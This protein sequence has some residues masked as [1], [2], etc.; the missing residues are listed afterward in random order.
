M[1]VGNFISTNIEIQNYDC[2]LND[3]LTMI[4]SYSIRYPN[5]RV[6]KK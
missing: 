3:I 5:Y 1:G 6:F 2:C 4:K